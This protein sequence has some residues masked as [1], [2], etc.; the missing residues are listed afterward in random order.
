MIQE[1]RA[2]SIRADGPDLV[3]S[4][5]G[6]APSP[7]RASLLLD[8]AGHLVGVDLGGEGF[9]R[10]VVMLGPHEAVATQRE[11]TLVVRPGE[12]RV[13]AAAAH[14]LPNPYLRS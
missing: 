2:T 14:A 9:G 8:H 10:T 1:R 13:P 11:S 7:T 3:V 5:E 6:E 12:L 4:F